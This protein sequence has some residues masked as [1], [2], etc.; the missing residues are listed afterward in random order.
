MYILEIRKLGDILNDRW[1]IVKLYPQEN[2]F[3]APDGNQTRNLM[4]TR[5]TL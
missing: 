2:D 1:T 5:E 3:W 4:M